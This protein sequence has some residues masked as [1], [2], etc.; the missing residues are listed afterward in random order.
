MALIRLRTDAVSPDAVLTCLGLSFLNEAG[1]L[2]PVEME[3]REA[4]QCQILLQMAAGG[5][6]PQLEPPV[7]TALLD[8]TRSRLLDAECVEIF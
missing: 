5:D 3:P 6:V 8:W 2:S 7:W 1:W 4:A